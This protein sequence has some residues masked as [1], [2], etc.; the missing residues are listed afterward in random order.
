MQALVTSIARALAQAFI[1]IL[2]LAQAARAE[3]AS[4]E[5]LRRYF[6]VSKTARLVDSMV[7]TVLAIVA[8][9]APAGANPERRAAYDAK[10]ERIGA[11]LRER[12]GWSISEPLVI[13]AYQPRFQE[14]EV[15]ALIAQAQS[16]FGQAYIERIAPAVLKLEPAV[17]AHIAARSAQFMTLN[18]DSTFTAVPLPPPLPG[19]TQAMALVMM[20]E[21]PGARERF[22]ANMSALETMTVETTGAD[23][24]VRVIGQSEEGQRFAR[25]LKEEFKFEEIAAVQARVMAADLSE[26]DIAALTGH[27]RNP[28]HAAQR[29]RIEQAET[30]LAIRMGRYIK[31]LDPLGLEREAQWDREALTIKPARPA[32][33]RRSRKPA[34]TN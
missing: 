6:A 27:H 30:E 18:P 5:S 14:S 12:T 24:V 33:A 7:E 13:G 2:A 22:D 29:I 11:T 28:E 20:L 4:T 26:A 21:W 32:K 19:S 10:H 3:P 31:A 8:P 16:P 1:V 23:G 9:P 34:R 25:L 15:Q 17:Q